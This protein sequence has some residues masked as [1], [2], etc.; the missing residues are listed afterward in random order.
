[1]LREMKKEKGC[2]CQPRSPFDKVTLQL[3]NTLQLRQF[4]QLYTG[5]TQSQ[6]AQKHRRRNWSQ[7]EC[8]TVLPVVPEIADVDREPQSSPGVVNLAF[9][10]MMLGVIRWVQWP[11]IAR[12]RSPGD[13][14]MAGRVAY[15]DCTCG[16]L[17]TPNV[18]SHYCQCK[19]G[20]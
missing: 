20:V 17:V 12:Q 3:S 5:R 18:D 1:M 14:V 2:K 19:P 15:G 7:Q 4:A 13:T 9:Q 16:S 8:V 11:Y 6:H 10:R